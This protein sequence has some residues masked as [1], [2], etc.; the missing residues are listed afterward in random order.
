VTAAVRI[1]SGRPLGLPGG[2][3]P[4]AALLAAL[5][6]AGCGAAR[7][8]G[9]AGV[10]RVQAGQ[11]VGSVL[12][13]GEPVDVS[14]RVRADVHVLGADA[15]I[16]RTAVVRGNVGVVGGDL[17]V[18]RGARV[19]GFVFDLNPSRLHL[20]EV[21]AVA[22][23]WAAWALF[24]LLLTAGTLALAL[25]LT[26]VLPR[27]IAVVGERTRAGPWL[28]ARVGL[29]SGVLVLVATAALAVTVVG[30]PAA[31]G[32]GVL[33]ALAVAAGL[34]G[35]GY[36]LGDALA[37]RI[38]ADWPGGVRKVA[39]GL[40]PLLGFSYIPFLGP[41]LLAAAALVGFGAA[42]TAVHAWVRRS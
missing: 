31:A 27:W 11:S 25:L 21:L 8:G 14:G 23:F 28:S 4:A 19:G 15:V 42:V 36:A 38:G 17:R 34:G 12:S 7:A 9:G 37:G 24:R 20:G 32:L 6:L 41:L 5:L 30:L 13:V 22:S 3:L 10:L 16:R 26:A 39:L 2:V 40:G 35:V 1:R 33:V 29:W 18:E